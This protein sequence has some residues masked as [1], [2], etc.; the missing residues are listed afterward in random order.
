MEKRRNQ[1]KKRNCLINKTVNRLA[2]IYFFSHEQP[3]HFFLRC[4]LCADSAL[5][6]DVEM[7]DH[8]RGTATP[9]STV[10]ED[11]FFRYFNDSGSAVEGNAMSYQ[12]STISFEDALSLG[13]ESS[14]NNE[15]PSGNFNLRS[16]ARSKS[17]EI[18]SLIRCQLHLF[19]FRVDKTLD[20]IQ[21][22][23]PRKI[24]QPD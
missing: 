17:A 24:L 14:N 21:H 22:Y 3:L 10:V 6:I 8:S 4:F 15:C 9:E 16:R 18:S 13:I 11:F 20:R 12:P 19:C 2:K 5:P 23:E 7:D 1:K